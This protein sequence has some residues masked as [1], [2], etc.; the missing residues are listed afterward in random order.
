MVDL[1]KLTCNGGFACTWVTR[2]DRVVRQFPAGVQI[3][4]PAFQKESALI[5]HRTDALFHPFKSH[6]RIEFA[7]TL[8]IGGGGIGEL[9]ER[10]IFLI[11]QR[12]HAFNPRQEDTSE[13]T[14]KNLFLN[15]LPDFGG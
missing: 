4:F 13:I 12:L 15:E 8:L 11:K 7:D 6:H 9:V 5:S 3:S 1:A 14:R 10:N 2:E